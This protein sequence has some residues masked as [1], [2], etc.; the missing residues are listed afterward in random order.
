MLKNSGKVY[1]KVG[2]LKMLYF[3]WLLHIFYSLVEGVKVAH[4]LKD[5]VNEGVT[6][7]IKKNQPDTLPHNSQQESM[8]EQQ[9]LIKSHHEY[10]Y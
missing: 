4:L 2:V 7:F 5:D 3:V 6:K 9:V 10:H 1:M 8:D